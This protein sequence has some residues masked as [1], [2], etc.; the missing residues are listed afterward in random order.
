MRGE[1]VRSDRYPF[2]SAE[3][4]GVDA[5]ERAAIDAKHMG[6]H[7]RDHLGWAREH[8]AWQMV[9]QMIVGGFETAKLSIIHGTKEPD[10][11]LVW[12]FDPFAADELI[13]KAQWFWE[14]VE[15]DI[16]IEGAQ[17]VETPAPKV[18]P[19][20]V[21]DFTGNNL[22]ASFATDWLANRNASK[23][24]DKA[25]KGLKE[26]VEADVARASGHGVKI[27]RSKA[28]SLLIKEV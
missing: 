16:P 6:E 10:T 1:W 20:R 17:A 15:K 22:W 27:E 26:L 23:T 3:F 12:E 25:A 19:E 13:A 11:S 21:V 28:G 7:H 24:F 5:F 18:K 4:D 2:L 9:Q 14:H 8:Y